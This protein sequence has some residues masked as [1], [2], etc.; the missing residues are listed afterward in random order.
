MQ[1]LLFMKNSMKTRRQCNSRQNMT[2]ANYL[3]KNEDENYFCIPN[4]YSY[5]IV[6][7]DFLQKNITI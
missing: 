2:I 3:Q 5:F 4:N 1:T 6:V 7:Y